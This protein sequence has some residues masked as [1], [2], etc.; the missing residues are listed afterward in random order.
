MQEKANWY[1]LEESGNETTLSF[2][3][4][5][6]AVTANAAGGYYDELRALAERARINSGGK[7]TIVLSTIGDGYITIK[8]NP[9]VKS[10][11][12]DKQ[13]SNEILKILH[14]ALPILG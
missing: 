9:A 1:V 13:V 5:V 14:S 10:N 12:S 4:K 11:L 2:D 7:I 6:C 8:S 3:P